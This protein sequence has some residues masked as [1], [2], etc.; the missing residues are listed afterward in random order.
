MSLRRRGGKMPCNL[1]LS[2]AVLGL[3]MQC[4]A[5]PAPAAIA[6]G[7][8]STTGGWVHAGLSSAYANLG[9]PW[10]L[11]VGVF[12]FAG[13][14][15]FYKKTL[16]TLWMILTG[17]GQGVACSFCD[18][19]VTLVLDFEDAKDDAEDGMCEEICPFKLAKC[20]E[21][22]TKLVD[23]LSSST[24]FPCEAL[25]FCPKLDEFGE[26]IECNYDIAKGC[27]P[28]EACR[29]KSR[30]PY[31]V[32]DLRPGLKRWKRYTHMM[33]ENVGALAAAVQS[34]PKCG[35]P[36]AHEIFCVNEPSGFGV[37]CE[38]AGYLLVFVVATFQSIR[39]IETPGGD[40]DRQW[41]SFWM[42]FFVF[43]CVERFT[44]VLLSR[45][46]M[47]YQLKLGALVW[48]MFFDG[49]SSLYYR[50]HRMFASLRRLPP[51]LWLFRRIERH[52]G[53]DVWEWAGY[54]TGPEPT[55]HEYIRTLEVQ[56]ERSSE[57]AKLVAMVR[58]KAQSLE[59]KV[60]PGLEHDAGLELALKDVVDAPEKYSSL[61]E[62]MQERWAELEVRF[63]QVELHEAYDIV[64]PEATARA[65]SRT[66]LNRA[67]SFVG[68][69]PGA[70]I[71]IELF[72]LDAHQDT[73]HANVLYARRTSRAIHKGINS[74]GFLSPKWNQ[75]IEMVLNSGNI[76]AAGVYH[77]PHAPFHRLKGKVW[78]R[79]LGGMKNTQVG[80][81]EVILA[82]LMDGRTHTCE[83][84]ITTG[85]RVRLSLKF[86]G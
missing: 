30:Y 53:W 43:S 85:G 10:V 19:M 28:L 1:L 57:I 75:S 60:S 38:Y 55:T 58:E 59:G 5:L 83:A 71:W 2:L 8:V 26:E 65:N 25:G 27:M 33:T 42:I 56:V 15:S 22:C 50:V 35:Q 32:C 4:A 81:F 40:D 47:Y 16:R 66:N 70:T 77:N 74:R 9:S 7:I 79:S 17:S 23:M 37:I 51:V 14:I 73:H 20:V 29:L 24:K 78:D 12:Q 3:V 72:L 54:Y 67:A 34:L 41:L 6:S 86:T 31:P 45:I 62:A 68:R 46:P 39:A 49:A 82:M 63:L 48:L 13:Q 36:G 84:T 52:V 61:L 21:M 11:A 76:N 80:E 44:A 18:E 64:F 69:P